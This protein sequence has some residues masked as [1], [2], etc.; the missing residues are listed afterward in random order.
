MSFVQFSSSEAKHAVL[1]LLKQQAN[2]LA[3]LGKN[4]FN[5]PNGL[6]PIGQWSP[7]KKK[8]EK[9]EEEQNHELRSWRMLKIPRPLFLKEEAWRLVVVVWYTV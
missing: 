1:S 9:T 2:P 6:F 3:F 8:K 5:F 4:A 7:S